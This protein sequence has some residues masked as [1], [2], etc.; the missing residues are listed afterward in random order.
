VLKN[1][2]VTPSLSWVSLAYLRKNV[3]P[4]VEAVV[5]QNPNV[6]VQG[7]VQPQTDRPGQQ[8]VQLKQPPSTSDSATFRAASTRVTADPAQPERAAS[9]FEAPPQGFAAKGYR[10]VLWSAQ[11]EN[12]D[13]L[14][15]SVYYR[16][17]GEK[18]WKALKEKVEQRFF[19]W[20]STTMPDGAYYLRIVASDEPSNPPADALE[21]ERISERFEVDNTPPVV[22][23][24]RAEVTGAE[25]SVLFEARDPSSAIAR[26]EYSVDA[27]EWT[28]VFPVGRLSDAPQASYRIVLPRL[29]PGEHTVVVR[30]FDQFENMASA[31]VT[32][33]MVR[34]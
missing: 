23:K 25:T 24:L 5:V 28:L 27:G 19:T 2:G 14:S 22:D 7:F 13:E 16:G 15:Y 6:R 29:N 26:A 8:A 3:A 34:R 11:D 33:V 20:D 21:G 31:K 32:F 30:V 4:T 17:E 10:G 1:R 12:G 18:S 9:R